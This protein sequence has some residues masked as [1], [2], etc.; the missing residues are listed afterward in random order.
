VT[1]EVSGNSGGGNECSSVVVGCEACSFRIACGSVAGVD[2]ASANTRT[3][4]SDGC[5]WTGTAVAS[6]SEKGK[7]QYAILS[8]E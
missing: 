8:E 7:N 6:D 3:K 4:A 1:P 2:A 5:S